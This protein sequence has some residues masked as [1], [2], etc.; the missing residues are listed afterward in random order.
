MAKRTGV[1]AL[2][3]AKPPQPTGKT[4]SLVSPGKAG[5]LSDKP[6][7]KATAAKGSLNVGRK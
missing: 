4:V 7:M 1:P 3:T 6:P 2:A 5:P